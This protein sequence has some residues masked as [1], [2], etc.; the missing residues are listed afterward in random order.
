MNY[1]HADTS[2]DAVVVVA[3]LKDMSQKLT[4]CIFQDGQ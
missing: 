2:K 4:K 3:S 1:G